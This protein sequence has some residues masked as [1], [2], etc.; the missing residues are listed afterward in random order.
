MKEAQMSPSEFL[1]YIAVTT[2]V[3]AVYSSP[4]RR[5]TDKR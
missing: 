3:F 2:V 1:G 4:W 5:Q